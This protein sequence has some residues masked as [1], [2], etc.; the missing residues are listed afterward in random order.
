MDI[1]M[2]LYHCDIWCPTIDTFYISIYMLQ[3]TATSFTLFDC[4]QETLR[5]DKKKNIYSYFYTQLVLTFPSIV[6]REAQRTKAHA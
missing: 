6:C 5:A 3:L 1:V 2:M 4:K